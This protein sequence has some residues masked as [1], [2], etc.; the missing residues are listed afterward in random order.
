MN[1]IVPIT[2]ARSKLGDLAELAVADKYFILTK[3]GSPTVALVD[4][5]YLKRLENTVRKITQKTYIDPSLEQY[6]REFSDEEVEQWQK[7]DQI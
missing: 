6:T 5:E 3:G 4:F 2:Q 1:N 7:E